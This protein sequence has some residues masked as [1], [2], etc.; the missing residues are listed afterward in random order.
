LYTLEYSLPTPYAYLPAGY[1]QDFN[2]T[3]AEWAPVNVHYTN[4]EQSSTWAPEAQQPQFS[5]KS[6]TDIVLMFIF[7]STVQ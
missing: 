6:T 3:R 2:A 1:H 7:G 4:L 5:S